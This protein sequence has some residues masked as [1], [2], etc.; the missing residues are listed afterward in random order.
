MRDR[1]IGAN[2]Q[3]YFQFQTAPIQLLF[4]D[5]RH[6]EVAWRLGK[7][8]RTRK[9]G[10]SAG[11]AVWSGSAEAKVVC[12]CRRQGYEYYQNTG[13]PGSNKYLQ[14][15]HRIP[16]KDASAVLERKCKAFAALGRP[17][18][19]DRL[20]GSTTQRSPYCR[21]AKCWRWP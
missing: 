14:G 19:P 21:P 13:R 16:G 1:N 8:R 10:S 7:S 9:L 11:R 12:S 6:L 18:A 4:Q 20:P 15:G 3:D 17:D 2:R 5:L